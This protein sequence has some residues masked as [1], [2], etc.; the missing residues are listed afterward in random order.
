MQK[1][2]LLFSCSRTLAAAEDQYDLH[3]ENWELRSTTTCF[4]PEKVG[5]ESAL[6]AG[7]RCN[8]DQ[9]Y[10]ILKN[11]SQKLVTGSAKKLYILQHIVNTIYVYNGRHHHLAPERRNC[12]KKGCPNLTKVKKWNRITN[13][14]TY[15]LMT[16]EKSTH[17][18]NQFTCDHKQ[19]TYI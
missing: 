12:L 2:Q 3:D 6:K 8:F 17:C 19:Y 5:Y 9:C 15:Q 1:F 13:Q 16:K 18:Q 11:E 10:P 14:L 7:K 4:E